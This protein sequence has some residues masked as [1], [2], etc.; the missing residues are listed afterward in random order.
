MK[1]SRDTWHGRNWSAWLSHSRSR[2]AMNYR[3]MFLSFVHSDDEW[4]EFH[5]RHNVTPGDLIIQRNEE[6]DYYCKYTVYEKPS[7]QA[8]LCMYFWAAVLRGPTLR[9]ANWLGDHPGVAAPLIAASLT[10]FIGGFWNILD[11]EIVWWLPYVLIAGGILGVV[12]GGFLGL[13]VAYGLS[14]HVWPRVR[15]WYHRRKKQPVPEKEPSIVIEHIKASKSR[16][17]PILEFED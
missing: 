2:R 3:P 5:K 6:N 12:V 14:Q 15:L 1:V 4:E 9:A 10:L 11:S 17:C 13:G 7:R 16:V 8:N